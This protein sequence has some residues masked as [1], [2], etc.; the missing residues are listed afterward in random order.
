MRFYVCLAALFALILW[1]GADESQAASSEPPVLCAI[2]RG[3]WC[4]LRGVSE[5]KLSFG[6][7]GVEWRIWD[8]Y[9]EDESG[10][11]LE[12]GDCSAVAELSPMIK[13]VQGVV[14]R[15][16]VTWQEVRLTLHKSGTCELRFLVPTP[17][18]AP[19]G[20][21]ASSWSSQV[22]L[23]EPR[24]RCGSVDAGRYIYAPLTRR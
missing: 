21:A 18:R 11:L 10:L 12:T 14:L 19:L 2:D 20:M 24:K 16:G 15:G 5:V 8:K 1:S 17:D 3:S 22:A 9:W 7:E 13:E 23:C 6:P 4:I